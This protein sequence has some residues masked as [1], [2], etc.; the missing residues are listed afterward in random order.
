MAILQRI[1]GRQASVL[2]AMK[3]TFGEILGTSGKVSPEVMKRKLSEYLK[4]NVT[5]SSAVA[6][7]VESVMADIAGSRWSSTDKLSDFNGIYR[8]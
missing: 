7:E 3:L 2:D 6:A 4:Y 8:R 1:A 5:D